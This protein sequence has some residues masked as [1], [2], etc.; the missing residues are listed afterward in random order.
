LGKS[1]YKGFGFKGDL[2]KIKQVL[3]DNYNATPSNPKA[4]NDQLENVNDVFGLVL[5]ATVRLDE[6]PLSEM[7]K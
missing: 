1:G 5:E 7:L 3:F 2:V 4:N 6:K